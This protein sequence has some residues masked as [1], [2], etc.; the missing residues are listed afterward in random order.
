MHTC[1][2]PYIDL[3]MMHVCINASQF[4]NHNSK[5]SGFNP[6]HLFHA[7]LHHLSWKSCWTMC[8]KSLE[9][10]LWTQNGRPRS[11]IFSENCNPPTHHGYK[12]CELPAIGVDQLVS[13]SEDWIVLVRRNKESIISAN[14]WLILK[15]NRSTPADRAPNRGILNLPPRH[16]IAAFSSWH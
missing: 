3:Y 5:C 4:C 15:G 1:M 10:P 13:W 9:M 2:R 14:Y 16:L 6:S 12:E 11:Y 7:F 8:E